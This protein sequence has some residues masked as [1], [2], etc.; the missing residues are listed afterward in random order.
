MNGAE[1]QGYARGSPDGRQQRSQTQQLHFPPRGFQ[2]PQLQGQLQRPPN[3]GAWGN[4]QFQQAVVTRPQQKW[5]QQGP[6]QN[7]QQQQQ[8]QQQGAMPNFQ[9]QGP[10]PNLQPQQ[11]QQNTR[12]YLQKQQQQQNPRPNFQT[13]KQQQAKKQHPGN[14]AL[15]SAQVNAGT[16]RIPSVTAWLQKNLN[17]VFPDNTTIVDRILTN[18]PSE[19]DLNKLSSYILEVLNPDR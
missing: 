14:P 16:V 5:N 6:K 4:G 15:A 11:Q 13:N 7:F 9:Q 18:H 3:N 1:G 8:Q 17:T 19:N 12:P 2:Q 10:Q